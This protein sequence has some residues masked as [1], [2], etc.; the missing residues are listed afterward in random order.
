[1]SGYNVLVCGVVQNKQKKWQHNLIGLVNSMGSLGGC[2]L[3]FGAAAALLKIMQKRELVFSLGTFFLSHHFARSLFLLLVKLCYR[4]Y[5]T[6]MP[7]FTLAD[8]AAAAASVGVDL[9]KSN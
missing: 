6:F 4:Y 5:N 1:M 7:S 9:V 2:C 8:A 3:L